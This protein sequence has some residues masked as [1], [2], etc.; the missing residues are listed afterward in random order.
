M[1]SLTD[2]L[3][4]KILAKMSSDLV[5]QNV[6]LAILNVTSLE[7]NVTTP[8]LMYPTLNAT[9]ETLNDV[10]TSTTLG[11]TTS[12]VTSVT[13]NVTPPPHWSQS[14]STE[15]ILSV[16]VCELFDVVML[17]VGLTGMYHGIDIDHPV[18][19]LLFCNIGFA[20]LVTIVNLA[21]LGKL[22]SGILSII[23]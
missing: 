18:Y 1:T 8:S 16:K 10:L 2:E 22:V 12:T 4:L 17:L 21:S 20:F 14:W 13:F 9:L 7:L 6:T 3:K 11:L 5:A 23:L 19:A 15:M